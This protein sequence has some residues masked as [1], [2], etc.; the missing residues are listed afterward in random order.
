L[1][2]FLKKVGGKLDVLQ[3]L[4]AT[5]Q[6]SRPW[7]G[8]FTEV[9]LKD[10]YLPGRLV[11]IELVTRVETESPVISKPAQQS[12]EVPF[13]AGNFH[14]VLALQG[15]P[16]YQIGGKRLCILLKPWGKMEGIFIIAV[17]FHQAGVESR[18]EKVTAFLAEVEMDISFLGLQ[19]LLSGTPE[20]ITVDRNPVDPDDFKDPPGAANRTR[21]LSRA[22]H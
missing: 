2:D 5:E 1:T 19:C 6:V 12:E 13:A 18:I 7:Q 3:S 14:N 17:V 15:M 8:A 11:A 21:C 22:W 4:P 16:L 20:H 9:I 10:R